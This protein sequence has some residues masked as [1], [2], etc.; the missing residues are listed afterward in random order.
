[1]TPEQK[2]LFEDAI[3]LCRSAMSIAGR[4]GNDTNWAAFERKSISVLNDYRDLDR[5]EAHRES[6]ETWVRSEPFFAHFEGETFDRDGAGYIDAN[7]HGAWMTYLVHVPK[8]LTKA[9]S[10]DSF[11]LPNVPIPPK[12]AAV[13]EVATVSDDDMPF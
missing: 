9:A 5:T 12:V 3:D 4:A 11:D 6:F 8:P 1:M 7:V 2:Q 13:S 10:C